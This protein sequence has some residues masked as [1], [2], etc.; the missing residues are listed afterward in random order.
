V[1]WQAATRPRCSAG[2]GTAVA[3]LTLDE[4]KQFC[5]PRISDCK[6]PRNASGKSSS[7]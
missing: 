7:M 6:I 1:T 4:V 3:E 5:R 2:A